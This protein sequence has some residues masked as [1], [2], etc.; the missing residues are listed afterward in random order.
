MA[1][2]QLVVRIVGDDKSLQRAFKSSEKSTKSFQ[3]RMDAV[4]TSTRGVFAAAGVAVGATAFTAALGEMITDASNLQEQMSKNQQVFGDSARTIEAWSQTTAQSFG[5]SQQA[6]LEATGTFGNLFRTVGLVPAQAS[7]MSRSLVELTA[8]LASF[9]NASPAD[10]LEAIRSGLIGEAEPMRR[11]GVLLSEARV[12][13]Q[14]LA[15]TGKANVKAL[16]DQEKA[17]ARYNIILRDTRSAQGDFARTQGGLANQTRILSAQMDDLSTQIGSVL[18]PALTDLAR[19]ANVSADAL[20]RIAG[21]EIPGGGKLGSF[22]GWVSGWKELDFLLDQIQPK[23]DKI[24]TTPVPS[25]LHTAREDF[26]L[27][28]A[29]ADQ[30]AANVKAG[31]AIVD[32]IRRQITAQRSLNQQLADS[33]TRATHLAELIG[34]DPKNLKLQERIADEFRTQ[35][36][37]R[38]DIA[39]AAKNAAQADRDAAK[40]AADA[41]RERER[42]RRERARELVEIKQ[43]QQQAR[44]FQ[45]LGLTAGGAQRAPGIEALRRRGAS[46][47]EQVKGTLLDTAKT[48]QQFNRIAK[49]LAEGPKKVGREMRLAILEMFNDIANALDQGGKQ[50]PLTKGGGLNTKRIL[51]GLGLS[52]DQIRELRGRLSGVSGAGRVLAP[53][54][55]AAFGRPLGE[56]GRVVVEAHTVVNLDGQ[57]IANVVTRRQQQARRRN[58]RQKRGPNRRG[59]EG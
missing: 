14:A 35:G 22:L 12:Q 19:L 49:V 8:D 41:R 13:Q 38:E 46:L 40:A 5:I 24:A 9:N 29:A 48:R 33:E 10:V 28:Q 57:Q 3:G 26:A 6:A 39:Q 37:I 59:S 44:Q 45:T 58:P 2:R 27:Q 34:A 43:Q 50:G 56:T 4:G 25:P 55:A 18:I 30:V 11:Y 32:A 47:R 15:T 51:E 20:G 36:R 42:E 17:V 21:I 54:G 16:S 53:A 7:V 1:E 52:P 31:G 23:L